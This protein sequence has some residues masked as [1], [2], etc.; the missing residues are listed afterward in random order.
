MLTLLIYF[1]TLLDTIHAR[2]CFFFCFCLLTL[3][4]TLSE[5]S[6]F[7]GESIIEDKES[8]KENKIAQHD[9]QNY[10][11]DITENIMT[12]HDDDIKKSG[13]EKEKADNPESLENGSKSG[14]LSD[15]D[16]DS[17][18]DTKQVTS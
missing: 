4:L 15:N 1:Q 12:E 16:S 7:P 3:I 13:V 8:G 17:K 11:V 18:S 6:L 2:I 14:S 9:A 10:K 5:I